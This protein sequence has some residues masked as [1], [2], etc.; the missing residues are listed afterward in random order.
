MRGEDVGPAKV[1]EQAKDPAAAARLWDVCE[2]LTGV[3]F[4]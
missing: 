2:E 4:V 3:R 1:S